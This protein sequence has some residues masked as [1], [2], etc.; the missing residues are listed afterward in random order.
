MFRYD[1]SGAMIGAAR[2]LQPLRQIMVS[3]IAES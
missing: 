2:K 1:M 3:N